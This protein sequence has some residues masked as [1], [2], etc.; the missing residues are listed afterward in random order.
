MTPLAGRLKGLRAER[1]GHKNRR[2]GALQGPRQNRHVI[3]LVEFPLIREIALAPR[4][5]NDIEA[6]AKPLAALVHRLVEAVVGRL[7]KAAADAE[8]EPAAADQIDQRVVLG[9]ADGI[10]M[11]K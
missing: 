6:F 5:L 2:R 10:V 1:G 9:E 7:D 11:W 4:T 3:G 8:I